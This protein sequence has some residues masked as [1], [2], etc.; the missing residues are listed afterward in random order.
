ME[1][2]TNVSRHDS[3][4]A[5]VWRGRPLRIF[6]VEDDGPTREDIVASLLADGHEVVGLA[7]GD[8]LFEC[9]RSIAAGPL[10]PPDLIAM[11]VRMPG[12][13]G[14]ALLDDLRRNGWA[15]PVVL[16]TSYVTHDIQ[17]R[18]ELA[19]SAEVISKPFDPTELRRAASRARESISFAPCER[20]WFR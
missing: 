3:A 4:G 9:L 13:S 14:V 20:A 1:A 19:G 2:R 6:V 17:F 16:V 15:I 10:R 5:R 12:R 8:E 11:D 7:C 18:A